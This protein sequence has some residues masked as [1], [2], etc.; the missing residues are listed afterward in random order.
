[1]NPYPTCKTC[2]WWIA[3][4]NIFIQGECSNPKLHTRDDDG[5]N[6]IGYETRGIATGRDFGC[7]HH[8][9]KCQP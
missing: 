7:I 5:A 3:P 4:P 9:D 2:R 8:E 1:M 6:P